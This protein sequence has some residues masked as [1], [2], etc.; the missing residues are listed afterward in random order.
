[1]L[2]ARVAFGECIL[3]IT[4]F[5]GDTLRVN[6]LPHKECQQLSPTHEVTSWRIVA[7]YECPR[8]HDS[9]D[10]A[11]SNK[12]IGMAFKERSK[13]TAKRLHET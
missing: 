6:L 4:I 2:I 11:G 9:T 5:K 13:A 1:M 7:W 8:N 3:M 12:E 10:E